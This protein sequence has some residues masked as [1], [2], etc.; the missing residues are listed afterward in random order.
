MEGEPPWHRACCHCLGRNPD[1]LGRLEVMKQGGRKAPSPAWA[2]IWL[3][4]SPLPDTE[5]RLLT[6]ASYHQAP[7]R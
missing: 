6:P 5:D 3:E 7:Q 4:S 1:V 2:G